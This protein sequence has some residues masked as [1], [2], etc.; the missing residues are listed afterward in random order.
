MPTI[1]DVQKLLI[2]KEKSLASAMDK[3]KDCEKELK[4]LLKRQEEAETSAKKEKD[5]KKKAA[6]EKE[7]KEVAAEGERVK[8]LVTEI[9]KTIPL[10][11]AKVEEYE[12]AV[13]TLEEGVKAFGKVRS[14]FLEWFLK[15]AEPMM[16]KHQRKIEVCAENAR[17]RAGTAEAAIE[18]GDVDGA[19]EDLELAVN[20]LEM[21]EKSFK[22]LGAVIASWAPE[23]GEQ[24]N[25]SPKE[26][27]IETTDTKTYA[28]VTTEV[29]A[30]FKRS[31][32]ATRDARALIETAQTEVGEASKMVDA[33]GKS[34]ELFESIIENANKELKTIAQ[35]YADMCEK[36][37][38]LTVSGEGKR[39][40]D[41][42]ALIKVGDNTT[43]NRA[44]KIA[45]QARSALPKL[46][47]GAR[48]MV[49]QA[50]DL[51]TRQTK[52]VPPEFQE[53]MKPALGELRG[54]MMALL[55]KH[56][57]FEGKYQKAMA[58][59]DE[60]EKAAMV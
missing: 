35:N 33:G 19:K 39:F 48:L 22:E 23:Y 17:K 11:T 36:L 38:G 55:V 12:K 9:K 29:Y 56:K 46:I 15:N 42:K 20:S 37:W 1:A 18:K 21:A 45:E 58:K 52:K 49:K 16:A 59:L 44:F 50:N 60:L 31:D 40:D 25:L 53:S 34:A 8:K 41:E 27:G 54:A 4:V 26:Y 24:R 51:V 6:L 13:E 7:A 57:A 2:E 47:E 3:V 14:D 5:G 32:A 28:A 30:C 43:L 10:T